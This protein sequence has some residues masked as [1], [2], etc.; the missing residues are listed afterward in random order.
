MNDTLIQCVYNH[1]CFHCDAS[2]DKVWIMSCLPGGHLTI[3]GM[4]LPDEAESWSNLEF[5]IPKKGYP[6]NSK[7][8][9]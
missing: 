5:R 7:P 6:K 3:V 8:P 9:A 4:K 1:I 2:L